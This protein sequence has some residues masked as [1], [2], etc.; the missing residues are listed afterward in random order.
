M[1]TFLLCITI[2]TLILVIGK[3]LIFILFS[4]IIRLYLK[5]RM[6]Q[7]TS[8][9][10]KQSTTV[11]SEPEK[12]VNEESKNYIKSSIRRYLDGYIRYMQF[13]VSYIPSHHIRDWIYKS[14]YLVKMA[15]KSIIYFGAEIRGSYNLKIGRGAIIGDKA[16]L[17]ARVGGIE[18]GENV[19][20]GSFVKLWTDSHDMNDPYFRGTP[21]K[22]GPI[23][24]GNRA[25]LGP[26]VTVIHS[27]TIGEG[28]VVAA[29][30]VVTK[31]VEPFAIM[32]G[33][34]AKKIGE[35]SQNLCYEF[36]G[37]YSPFY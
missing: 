21:G 4:P 30:S 13:Q 12:P 32:G 3:W 11:V 23:K 8:I 5:M 9:K 35:R 10:K 16:V 19:Q 22:R 37:A 1:I 6:R 17:D 15:P 2:F 29:G 28:A 20:L 24:I 27:V 34:P 18:I 36:S 25:W 33:I 14:V 7:A 26:N 31:D